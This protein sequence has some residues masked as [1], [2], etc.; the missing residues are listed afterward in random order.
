MNHISTE[1]NNPTVSITPVVGVYDIRNSM[2]VAGSGGSLIYL[3]NNDPDNFVIVDRVYTN[4]IESSA[5]L[6]DTS[7]FIQILMSRVLS[8]GTGTTLIAH[9][10]NNSIIDVQPQTT[11]LTNATTSGGVELLRRYP[12]ISRVY[13]QQPIIQNSDGIILGEGNNIEVFISTLSSSVVEIDMRFAI[14]SHE[15]LGLKGG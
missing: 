10:T 15:D 13:F 1:I 7:T 8:S 9:N 11:I 14:A 3:V 4:T 2:I 6:P 12:D 5:T